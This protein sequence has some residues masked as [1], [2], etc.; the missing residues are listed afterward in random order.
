MSLDYSVFIIIILV[1]LLMFILDHYLFSPLIDILRKRREI[2][3]EARKKR[4]ETFARVEELLRC[5][6]EEIERAEE[7]GKA[8]REAF[9]KEGERMKRE[10]IE[11]AREKAEEMVARAERELSEEVARSQRLLAVEGKRLSSELAEKLL[12]MRGK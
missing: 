12:G 2:V 5:Y 7:E 3:T 9:R 8:V 6:R 11:R 4:D 1:L 10:I